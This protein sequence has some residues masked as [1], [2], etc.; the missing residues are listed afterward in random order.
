M[1]DDQRFQLAQELAVAAQLEVELDTLDDGGE[2]LLVEPC[3]LRDEQAVQAHAGERRSAPH[4]QRLLEQLPSDPRLTGRARLTRPVQRLVPA[5]DVALSGS[6]IQSVTARVAG[7]PAAIGARRGQPLAQPRDVHL[8]AVARPRRRLLAPH[9]IDQ[10]VAGHDVTR[11]QRQGREQRPRPLTPERHRSAVH[12]RL[13]R[14]EQLDPQPVGAVGHPNATACPVSRVR[15]LYPRWDGRWLAHC[16]WSVTGLGDGAPMHSHTFTSALA[17]AATAALAATAPGVSSAQPIDH[18]SAPVTA[19]IRQDLRSPDAQD[20]ADGRGTFNSPQV[21]VV[22]APAQAPTRPAPANGID[23]ADA[24][25]G[26]GSLLALAVAL[27]GL[28]LVTQRRR[29]THAAPPAGL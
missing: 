18:V 2:P 28:L 8:Q 11:H 9:L 7:Q 23:W 21:V 22:K 24:G 14:T 1:R 17:V 19:H 13:D 15:R 4:G 16:W 20:L 27:G 29:A 5:V 10:L 6:H 26:A 12:P 25:I 3:A